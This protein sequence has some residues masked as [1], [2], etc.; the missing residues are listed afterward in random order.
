M[1][2]AELEVVLVA[3]PVSN[4]LHSPQEL[5]GSAYLDGPDDKEAPC[6][7]LY[8]A[9]VK[10]RALGYFSGTWTVSGAGATGIDSSP[11]GFE[12]HIG[13]TIPTQGDARPR[14]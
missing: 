9:L 7:D 11:K 14:P 8:G 12:N 2:L 6:A 4:I 3:M 5:P 13:V 10:M 1:Q